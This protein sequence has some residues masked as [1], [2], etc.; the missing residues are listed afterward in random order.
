MPQINQ[1]YLQNYDFKNWRARL[2]YTKAQAA[3]TLGIS[4]SKYS[5]IE[6]LGIGQRSDIWAC[7]GVEQ[8]VNSLPVTPPVEEQV[9]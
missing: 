1:S 9:K 6:K 7:Y 2:G 4:E 3:V 8:Y 5:R